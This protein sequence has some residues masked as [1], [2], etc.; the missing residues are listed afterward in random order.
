MGKQDL[1][2]GLLV[3]L[4][5]MVMAR[6]GWT[7]EENLQSETLEL[8]DGIPLEKSPWGFDRLLPA[9]EVF[10]S[11]G[12]WEKYCSSGP[13]Q[14]LPCL[15]SQFHWGFEGG[16]RHGWTLQPTPGAPTDERHAFANQPTYGD[17]VSAERPNISTEA[18]VI[19]AA[20]T[21]L[22]GDF[23]KVPYPVGHLGDYWL[24]TFEDR[25]GPQEPWGR[26]QGTEPQGR[27][28][29]PSFPVQR[30]YIHFLIGG[31][32][33]VDT[34]GIALQVRSEGSDWRVAYGPDG[35]TPLRATG[36]SLHHEDETN[37]AL[38]PRFVSPPASKDWSG[39]FDT[40]RLLP[41]NL[42]PEVPVPGTGSGG[43]GVTRPEGIK[44]GTPFIPHEPIDP[45][46]L[47]K[48]KRVPCQLQMERHTFFV[49]HLWGQEARLVAY[50]DD[51]LGHIEIDDILLTDLSRTD[52][53]DPPPR[54]WGWAD[55]HA[56]PATH[57]GFQSLGVNS[58]AV[59]G[60]DAGIAGRVGDGKVFHGEPGMAY[61]DVSDATIER[62]LR[63]CDGTSHGSPTE[64]AHALVPMLEGLRL[65]R[66]THGRHGHS[67]S[68][69]TNFGSWPRWH[70]AAHQ[71]MHVKWMH[72]AY[73]SGQRL[74]VASVTNNELLG[75]AMGRSHEAH[76]PYLSDYGAVRRFLNFMWDFSAANNEW[77]EIALTPG[78]ARRI[79]R[80]GRM[81][82]ILALE[83]DNMGDHCPGSLEEDEQCT[84]PS[85]S[86]TVSCDEG[87]AETECNHCGVAPV[88]RKR[89][90]R[91]DCRT[92]GDWTGRI[93]R[94]YERGVR[95]ITP[96]HL[97][98]NSLGGCAA[99]LE[100]ANV[101]NRFQNQRYWSLESVVPQ[102]S[103]PATMISTRFTSNQ[104]M[105]GFCYDLACLDNGLGSTAPIKRYG[106]SF[107]GPLPDLLSQLFENL[108]ALLVTGRTLRT[109][110]L[111]TS[112]QTGP[113]AA[114]EE[115]RIGHINA[116][117]LNGIVRPL[118]LLGGTD[119]AEG[120]QVLEMMTRR[121]IVLDI[122][123]ASQKAR[124]QILGLGTHSRGSVISPTCD[125]S[126]E[127][128]RCRREAYP[129]IASHTPIRSLA[130]E[131]DENTLYP[132]QVDRIREIGGMI[133]AGTGGLGRTATF[134]GTHL[135][136]AHFQLG[137]RT[138][139]PLYVNG[140]ANTCSGSSR[141]FAQS[142][143]HAVARMRGTGVAI[144]TDFNGLDGEPSPRFDRHGCH[145]GFEWQTGPALN[146][147]HYEGRPRS[148]IQLNDAAPTA[149]ELLPTFSPELADHPPLEA[150]ATGG[151]RFD[152]NRDGLAHYGMMPDF[153]QDLRAVGV[154]PEQLGVMFR[155]AEDYIRLWERSCRVAKSRDTRSRENAAWRLGCD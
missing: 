30:R 131:G 122:A 5:A 139:L 100:L 34:T 79:I 108:G 151:R 99:Y 47:R 16:N 6:C 21:H 15:V 39:H 138:P 44:G 37:P 85:G 12:S 77:M 17:N 14:L 121:G 148:F 69:A 2:A 152:L 120:P 75:W 72:R 87:R 25:P 32:C 4:G 49:E 66:S 9:P 93:Q 51:P 22:G 1:V 133:G 136:D 127:P 52:L 112:V 64:M 59:L 76:T 54:I 96:I 103:D 27:F 50:D 45:T 104:L 31:G 150:D 119:L 65:G 88:H 118:S 57:L 90:G 61:R 145:A 41:E 63:S 89:T 142:Y 23:W 36:L 107:F 154:T 67:G 26:N 33:D 106:G 46:P 8:P 102:T 149:P 144:G 113:Y 40:D 137:T 153:L 82:V 24:A 135:D 11:R 141:S 91:Q 13:R 146:Y 101:S 10:P 129:V 140:V 58:E 35:R 84:G 147:A 130:G 19:Q 62:D 73:E 116:R 155:S 117:G 105:A 71:Q 128:H 123:H 83:V 92:V 53:N 115:P 80:S 98:D 94:L 56:H 70:T 78:H 74:M 86:E 7:P 48:L 114:P 43:M 125:W 28:H 42:S 38:D 55:T 110:T 18:M 134:A 60:I 95:L 29:S 111:Q 124:D 20:L 97:T 68:S 126:T 3:A 81:A 132:A 143:L 109:P